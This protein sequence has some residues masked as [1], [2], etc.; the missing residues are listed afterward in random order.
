MI[1]A[2]GNPVWYITHTIHTQYIYVGY[3][4]Y[5]ILKSKFI[6]FLKFCFSVVSLCAIVKIQQIHIK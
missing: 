4:H 6:I 1:T 2:L 3:I 5:K